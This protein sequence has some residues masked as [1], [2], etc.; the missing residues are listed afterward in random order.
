[1]I[2]L[3]INGGSHSIRSDEEL[4]TPTVTYSGESSGA[5]L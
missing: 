5:K 3:G 4:T 1:M 2:P